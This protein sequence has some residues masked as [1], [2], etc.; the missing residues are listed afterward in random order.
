VNPGPVQTERL[1]NIPK[2]II[3]AQKKGTPVE[4]RL[5]TK[6][7]AADVVAWLAGLTA[8]GLRARV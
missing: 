5:G 4:N 6:E 1:G 8:N 2:D 3:E 7:E